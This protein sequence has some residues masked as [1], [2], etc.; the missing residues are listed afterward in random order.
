MS[1]L[2]IKKYFLG[3]EK[4]KKIAVIRTFAILVFS[5]FLTNG[6]W[7][8]LFR[9]NSYIL[10]AAFASLAVYSIG[11]A[12]AERGEH[13]ISALVR[14]LSCLFFYL[15]CFRTAGGVGSAGSVWTSS[16]LLGIMWAVGYRLA[17]LLAFII[18]C[19]AVYHTLHS[20]HVF[21]TADYF[22]LCIFL[23]NLGLTYFI[24]FL[25]KSVSDHHLRR[26]EKARAE[27]EAAKHKIEA[28]NKNI[29]TILNATPNLIAIFGADSR[30]TASSKAFQ[31]ALPGT[32]NIY[33]I[34]G[35]F[36]EKV[37]PVVKEAINASLG[38]N[39]LNF[40]IN[41]AQLPTNVIIRKE[42]FNIAW[43]ALEDDTHT[44][45]RIQFEATSVEA[46]YSLKTRIE[47]NELIAAV[48]AAGPAKTASFVKKAGTQLADAKYKAE[49]NLQA[50]HK[51]A[52]I[53]LHTA[54]GAARTLGFAALGASI[55]KA[56]DSLKSLNLH[57]LLAHIEAAVLC[58]EELKDISAQF[59]SMENIWDF[60]AIEKALVNGSEK[61]YLLEKMPCIKSMVEERE[62]DVSKIAADLGKPTPR[63]LMVG[64]LSCRLSLAAADAF[65]QVL[66]H[67]LRNALDHGLENAEERARLKKAENGTISFVATLN[68]KGLDLAISDDGRGLDL[69]KIEERAVKLGIIPSER[70][71]VAAEAA[72]L[73]FLSGFST[74]NE[75]GQVSGRGVGMDAI[76]SAIE[77]IKGTV[78]VQLRDETPC[79]A[80]NLCI[81]IPDSQLFHRGS[82]ELLQ[83]NLRIL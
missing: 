45:Q 20:D 36:D 33:D 43:T 50:N 83:R 25:F 27:V 14:L 74:A 17:A 49:A 19:F 69:V 80:W 47:R 48:F 23:F 79:P 62:Q 38:E 56:E 26:S 29:A 71:L 58:L 46:I 81:H 31:K 53:R 67:L 78:H 11:I 9:D 68:E 73:I 82:V 7:F 3:G 63:F 64:P 41:Q 51:E 66:I 6:L 15:E 21:Q 44:V 61:D 37:R 28:V 70:R 13:R 57:S 4:G 10:M 76:R 8:W 32:S 5:L 22:S 42:N 72:E 2:A 39:V 40:E 30:L 77:R 65:D 18:S 75:V 52:F 60:R 16:I 1:F 55:H 35:I 59:H 24:G 54:K 12:M 34:V